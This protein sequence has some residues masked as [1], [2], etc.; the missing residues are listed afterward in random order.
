M[1]ERAR[2][3]KVDRKKEEALKDASSEA[4][5]K[6]SEKESDREEVI[7]HTASGKIKKK[8]YEKKTY[9]NGVVKS[10][11]VEVQIK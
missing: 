4:Y 9:K 10:R 3:S 8:I 6:K 2:G 5:S 7:I 11:L 1:E